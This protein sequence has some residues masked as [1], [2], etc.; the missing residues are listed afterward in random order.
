MYLSYRMNCECMMDYLTK[1]A[2]IDKS[3]D[4][5]LDLD[6][7]CDYLHLPASEEVKTI[8]NIYDIVSM[9]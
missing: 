1:F 5:F 9:L 8:F 7:F 3:K 2:E 6:E 4:G